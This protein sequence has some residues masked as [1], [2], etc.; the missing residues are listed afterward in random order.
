MGRMGLFV[1][2]ANP[3]ASDAE[4]LARDRLA[5]QLMYLVRGNPVV[6]YGD[7][8]GFVGDGGDQDAR[9]DMFPS[10]VKTYN[11]DDLI[12]TDATTADSN[13]DTSHPLYQ[14]IARLAQLSDEHP[15]LRNGAQQTR[16]AD[17]GPG[18]FAFSR[19]DREGQ[20]EYVVALNNAETAKTADIPTAISKRLYQ[21]IYGSAPARIKTDADKRLHV[22]VPA[23]S[24]VVYESSG[25]VPHSH[26]APSIELTQPTGDVRD[27]A[28]VRAD[29]GGDSF[30]EVTFLARVGN[31]PW[32][33]IGTD[34]N[35][36]YRVF[37][38]VADL[39][40]GTQLQYRAV[41]LDNA[42]HTRTSDIRTVRVA[43]PTI[44]LEAPP[45][46]G[47]VRGEVEV[48]ATATAEHSYYVVTFQRR[49]GNGDWADIGTDSSS[50]VYT[51][52]D[53]TSGLAD[54]SVVSD[55]ALLTSAPAQIAWDKP[56]PWQSKDGY[57]VVFEI[58][59]KDDTK[60]VNFIVHLP[61]GD[62]VPT[63]REPGGDRSFVPLDHQDIWLKQGDPTIYFSQP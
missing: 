31:G 61:S 51:A 63:T 62:S 11:D 55:R 16:Y 28:E 38:D 33:P 20:R 49:V 10:Q 59:L 46:G 22:T 34:D 39:A 42:G 50:P 57:G 15:A 6:Y 5:H 35:S 43:P 36:A 41:V 52:F 21:R 17:D 29:V 24:A 60:P 18:V 40:P 8:Q 26:S 14:A 7:E 19:Y 44:A 13:F 9:Q 58:P 3:G 27:R 45:D 12:G 1:R 54:G 4:V 30:Y 2:Q 23:L 48:R 47:H 32:Q 25:R 37:Q 53:D 56:W